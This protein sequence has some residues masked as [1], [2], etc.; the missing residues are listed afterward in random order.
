MEA[1]FQDI[2]IVDLDLSKTTWSRVHDSLRVMFLRLDRAPPDNDWPR[3]FFEERETRIVAR[4]RGL[5]IEDGYIS[6]DTLPEEV[7]TI[8]L[9]DIRQSL[10]YAN[11]KYR[12]LSKQRQRKQLDGLALQRSEREE[13]LALQ[14][15]VRGLIGATESPLQVEPTKAAPVPVRPAAVATTTAE[16]DPLAEFELRRNALKQVFRTAA[17]P[18]KEQE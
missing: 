16:P 10:N 13:L 18:D 4:R 8:H 3:L 14:A 2:C 6:F 17:S 12:E 5:W 7:E 9:P 11:R 15:R 1:E